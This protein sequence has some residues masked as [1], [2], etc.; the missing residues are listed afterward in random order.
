VLEWNVEQSLRR[1]KTDRIDLLQLHTCSEQALRRGDVIE[2]LDRAR[3][4]GKARYIGY[5]GDGPAALYAVQCGQFDA[6]QISVNIADQE[7]IDSILPLARQRGMGVIAKRP[8][9]NGCWASAEKPAQP[10]YHAYWTRLRELEYGFLKDPRAF[11]TAL[12]FTLRAPGVDTAIVGTISPEHLHEN[13]DHAAADGLSD[14]EFDAIRAR[15]KEVA[16]P[17]WVGQM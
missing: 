16:R 1:L 11:E 12:K 2:V 13:A 10:H 6:L 4:A 17:D 7:A 3:R 14:P 5:S 15:W 8:V 9:A